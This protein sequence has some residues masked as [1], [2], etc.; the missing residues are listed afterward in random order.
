MLSSMSILSAAFSLALMAPA[1]WAPGAPGAPV[2]Y[3]WSPAPAAV[4]GTV[5]DEGQAQALD[6]AAA[7]AIFEANLAAITGRNREE[8][9]A[10][11]LN[12]DR[13][14]RS[15][16]TGFDLG[17]DD[18]AAGAALTGSD[19]WP[20]QLLARDVQ[21]TW[22][23]TG[24]VYGT[25]R[26]R[27]S[28]DGSEWVEGLSE[29]LFTATADGWKIALTTAFEVD[30]K[31]PSPP[32]ALVGATVHDGTGGEPIQDAVIVLRDGRIETVGPR[33][34]VTVPAGIDTLDLKG[35]HVIPGLIDSH[36][37][38]S[39]TGWVDGRPD[40]GNVRATHPY[41][42]A[43]ATNQAHPDRFHRAFL[44]NG[45]TA[46]FDN[47][48]YPWTRSLGAATEASREAPHVVAAGPLLSTYDPGLNLFD[49][50]QMIFPQT[51]DEARAMVRS[52]AASG[53]QAI[54]FWFVVQSAAD[55]ETF[56]PLL[57]A[58][59]E[60]AKA[61]GL[62]LIVHATQLEA[63]RV[64]VAAGASLLVHSVDDAAIDEA[65]IDACVAQ[66]TSLC[67]TLTVFDGYAQLYLREI[68]EEV[69]SQLEFVHPT[70][71]ARV[72]ATEGLESRG[73]KRTMRASLNA[74]A[75]RSRQ[76]M[77]ANLLKLHQ[78]GVPIVMGTDAGNPLTLHGPSV[79]PELEAMQAAG[80]S[81]SEVLV[82][83]TSK[84]AAVLGRA[85]DLGQVRAGFVADL[86]ILDA[87]PMADIQNVRTLSRVVR[88]GTVHE[89]SQL[90]W[91]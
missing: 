91:D 23:R 65:F 72:L 37:H 11:Y 7:R 66:G 58:T 27:V 75:E 15:G 29:R 82:A 14:V 86:V 71:R 54:K 10:T 1:N 81:P 64:A 39:Q 79:F 53:S 84:A 77:Y 41:E 12:S 55:I 43:M 52:H 90:L 28:F 68:S 4:Q 67:P 70:V 24:L 38:Y 40:A 8:Y 13:L 46:V 32:V 33:A 51:E 59:G 62:P 6:L 20:A 42:E 78:A 80:L 30:D 45:I 2:A 69:R 5:G 44:A 9:L 18:L 21:L 57:M 87:D 60:E 74:R 26:Y 25:Y 31:T 83:A 47:G 48:G 16:A 56:T 50:Q 17:W 85:D 88:A 34:E 22:M 35:K 19:D 89:R 49:R 36:V 63:A 3:G 73:D 76:V 61:T